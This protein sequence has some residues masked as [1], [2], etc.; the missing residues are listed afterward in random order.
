MN[1]NSQ[2]PRNEDE[3]HALVSTS[4]AYKFTNTSYGGSPESKQYI[5]SPQS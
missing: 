4:S 2:S 3:M 1:L 5:M